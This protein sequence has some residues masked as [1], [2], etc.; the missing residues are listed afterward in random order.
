MNT[1]TIKQLVA[2]YFEGETSL[3]EEQQLRAYFQQ[4]VVAEELQ[5]Y[6]PLFQYFAAA[7][8]TTL[9]EQFDARVETALQGPA[10][11]R[12]MRR[13][14][15][16]SSVAASVMLVIGSYFWY[17]TTEVSPPA[18]TQIDWKKY[19]ISDP[20]EAYQETKAALELLSRKMNKGAKQA[21]KG[22]DKIRTGG[23]LK[24]EN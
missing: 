2:K 16:L 24:I 6:Q 5:Q 20:D 14:V 3:T 22:M 15:Q 12:F 10:K 13:V 21:A 17:N 9:P 1:V 19:E 11:R 8:Q 23:K 7:K 18:A 4:A